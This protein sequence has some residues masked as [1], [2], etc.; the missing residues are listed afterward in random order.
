MTDNIEQYQDRAAFASRRF[1]AWHGLGT[2][3]QDDV[4]TAE[5]LRLASLDNWD[6][7]CVPL[8]LPGRYDKSVYATVRTS[9]FD[10]EDDVLGIVGE[11]YEPMQNAD[12]FAF[13]D[14]IDGARWETAGSIKQGSQVFG[15]L[16]IDHDVVIDANGVGDVIKSYLLLSTSHDGS[17]AIQAS[18][19]PTRVVCQNTLNLALGAVKQFVKVRHTAT[20]EAKIMAAHETLGLTHKYMDAFAVEAAALFETQVTMAE[21]YKIV[22]A[23]YP[24]PDKDA[25]GSFTKWDNKVAQLG[26]I[27]IGPTQAGITGTGWGVLNALT[28]RMDWFRKPHNGNTENA[29]AAASGFDAA[30][31]A[32]KN[33]IMKAVK[34]LVLV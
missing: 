16:A 32:E 31:N 24:K 13:G 14:T 34:S 5:I 33:R 4:T 29:Y 23:I 6:V 11:R 15:S 30:A 10:G 28:E 22:E 25:K 21:F 12:L 1:P 9:P 7:R 17:L 2:V 18:I 26:E 19:T 20:A 8:D 3:F 27:Y